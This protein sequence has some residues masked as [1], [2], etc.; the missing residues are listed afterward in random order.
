MKNKIHTPLKGYPL[1]NSLT[2]G[3]PPSLSFLMKIIPFA[4][5]IFTLT[6]QWCDI[7]GLPYTCYNLCT[8]VFSLQFKSGEAARLGC[9]MYKI[10]KFCFILLLLVQ[11]VSLWTL[12]PK[13]NRTA[14]LSL[15]CRWSLWKR[16][17][18][19]MANHALAL[20]KLP[21]STHQILFEQSKWY[22]PTRLQIGRKLQSNHKSGGG[23]SEILGALH[24]YL[25]PCWSPN[26]QLTVLPA[27]HVHSHRPQDLQVLSGPGIMLSVQDLR[28]LQVLLLSPRVF[29][30]P[31][32]M[33]LM[34]KLHRIITMI[35]LILKGKNG[36]CTGFNGHRNSGV[37]LP[38]IVRTSTLG[39][40]STP[41]LC[42]LPAPRKEL[43]RPLFFKAQLCP[44]SRSQFFI[45]LGHIYR[46]IG[47]YAPLLLHTYLM[48]TCLLHSK[49][50]DPRMLIFSFIVI[51][52]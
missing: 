22:D 41:R 39:I 48:N 20:L 31:F 32:S 16:E 18:T 1:D 25:P 44:L 36:R 11:H 4:H 8:E 13:T 30:S 35:M 52:A 12:K 7:S 40:E 38:G 51:L 3:V 49:L 19:N 6:C 45:L 9:D 46:G 29:K 23:K 37:P 10:A 14:S 21:H 34:V 5:K 17:R 27:C 47:E 28:E 2:D 43:P 24:Q 33:Y 26:L 15:E 42:L 50:G